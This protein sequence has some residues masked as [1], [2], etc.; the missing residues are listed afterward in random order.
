MGMR[1]A[2]VDLEEAK[3]Y[4]K[5][6]RKGREGEKKH[7]VRDLVIESLQRKRWNSKSDPEDEEQ[8]SERK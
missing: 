7:P 3:I 1:E 5:A 4:V 6:M 2:G 8:G